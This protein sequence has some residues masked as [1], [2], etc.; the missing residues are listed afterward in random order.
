MDGLVTAVD[1]TGMHHYTNCGLDY[2]WLVDGFERLETPY[3]PGMRIH[4]IDGLLKVIADRVITSPAPLR[5]QEVRFL[6]SLL[7][8]SQE[9]LAHV[10]RQT[11]GTVTRWEKHR[12]K[13]LP[14]GSDTALRLFYAAQAAGNKAAKEISELLKELDE[15]QHGAREERFTDADG[16]R[17]AA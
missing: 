15:I 8:L 2:V 7:D 17:A 9:G 16:W 14:G 10:L 4:D 5:G 11:R 1:H 13:P 6:R 12:N 3:G